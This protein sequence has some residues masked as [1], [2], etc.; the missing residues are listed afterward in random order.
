MRVPLIICALA[1]STGAVAAPYTGNGP[2]TSVINAAGGGDYLSLQAAV[3]AINANPLTGGD[4]VFEIASNLTVTTKV[5]MA[6]NTNGNTIT[7]RPASGATPTITFDPSATFSGWGGHWVIGAGALENAT[8]LIPTHNIVIDGFNGTDNHALTIRNTNTIHGTNVLSF[9]G[10]SDNAIVRNAR[11]IQNRTDNIVLS[12]LRLGSYNSGSFVNATPDNALFENNILLNNSIAGSVISIDRSGEGSDTIGA[13]GT[14]LRGN[15]ITAPY[16]GINAVQHRSLVIEDNVLSINAQIASRDAFGI[17]FNEGT[18]AASNESIIVR[19]NTIA[20]L[21]TIGAGRACYGIRVTSTAAA[22]APMTYE[23]TNNVIHSVATTITAPDAPSRLNGLYLGNVAAEVLIA[24]NSISIEDSAG[25]AA[26][27]TLASQN[28]AITL[29][30][31]S[32]T[33]AVVVKNNV[34]RNSSNG[35]AAIAIVAPA[36]NLDV[37]H[38]LYGFAGNATL[39]TVDGTAYSS[40]VDLQT[41]G[42]GDADSVVLDPFLDS[43][44]RWTSLADLALTGVGLEAVWGAPRLTEVSDDIDGNSRDATTVYKGAYELIGFEAKISD[45]WMVQ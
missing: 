39:A 44:G 8:P 25:G 18:T 29:E 5:I 33:E 16:I 45:W 41:N 19:R 17:W 36:A 14:I 35:G 20:G 30:N 9:V 21:T 24:H 26:P 4:W 12:C 1:L 2:G 6:Q 7:F 15:D 40:I 31:T 37:D 43:A 28:G 23:I 10:D 38:N 42:G 22:G 34:V 11:I 3:N 32:N 13:T 27:A